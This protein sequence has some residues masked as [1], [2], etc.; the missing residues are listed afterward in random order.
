V[1]EV[2]VSS[3][4]EASPPSFDYN[5][6]YRVEDGIYRFKYSSQSQPQPQLSSRRVH[7]EEFG[8]TRESY[9]DEDE[10]GDEETTQ[11]NSGESVTR[12]P[13]QINIDGSEEEFT[14]SLSPVYRDYF[15]QEQGPE[16]QIANPIV[17]EKHDSAPRA[18]TVT[19]TVTEKTHASQAILSPAGASRRP[20]SHP[21]E[22]DLRQQLNANANESPS[23][24]NHHE[25]N[26]INLFVAPTPVLPLQRDEESPSASAPSSSAKVEQSAE[27]K[28]NANGNLNQG[29]PIAITSTRTVLLGQSPSP[30]PTA[31]TG[32]KPEENNIAVVS[33][34]S[35]AKSGEIFP[36]PTLV[37]STKEYKSVFYTAE[38]HPHFTSSS[39]SFSSSTEYSFFTP[40]DEE[41]H[42]HHH[43]RD[44]DHEHAHH[45][46]HSP[47]EKE[48]E[49][50]PSTSSIGYWDSLGLKTA[51][52]DFNTSSSEHFPSPSPSPPG[53][54]VGGFSTPE[55]ETELPILS[56]VTTPPVPTDSSSQEK[57]D[58]LNKI[59][60]ES[61]E[62]S[63]K[64]DS[65]KEEVHLPPV[66]VFIQILLDM[67]STQFC[68]SA[69]AFKEMIILIYTDNKR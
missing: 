3:A 21:H 26:V 44:H 60:S 24:L 8:L 68:P 38:T 62:N 20:T 23:P 40:E 5:P 17:A 16:A 59:P 32:A 1:S 36:T 9:G 27:S 47:E 42:H 29:E 18:V 66:A 64:E 10:D 2:E 35:P 65:S 41:A 6:S 54:L 4:Y 15:S 31:E 50:R 46:D 49:L 61:E 58:D 25:D 53:D 37:T 55:A 57:E 12:A 67:P 22:N 19:V 51:Q 43:D 45:H 11:R 39:Y 13:L 63:T 30:T 56:P 14:S 69:K 52:V 33:R 7:T 48:E 34:E 28:L